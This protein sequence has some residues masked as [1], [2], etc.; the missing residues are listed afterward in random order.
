MVYCTIYPHIKPQRGVVA[1]GKVA[2]SMHRFGWRHH[3]VA[4]GKK[5]FAQCYFAHV[6]LRQSK[7]HFATF[8]VHRLG[9]VGKVGCAQLKRELQRQFGRI[10]SI[11]AVAIIF[12]GIQIVVDSLRVGATLVGL[13]TPK[14]KSSRKKQRCENDGLFHIWILIGVRV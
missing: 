11:H 8:P 2:N 3:Q 5:G 4:V 14:H 9:V 10:S 6:K 7:L 12:L 13:A 1:I